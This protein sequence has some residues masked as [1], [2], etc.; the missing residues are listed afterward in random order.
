MNIEGLGWLTVG[1]CGLCWLLVQVAV[2]LFPEKYK[3]SKKMKENAWRAGVAF[4]VLGIF[5]I[6]WEDM[7]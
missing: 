6:F 1:G 7:F 5:L 4:W 2:R 3:P